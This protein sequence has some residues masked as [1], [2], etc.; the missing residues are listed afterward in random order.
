MKLWTLATLFTAVLAAPAPTPEEGDA[1]V[2]LTPDNFKDTISAGDDVWWIKFYSPYC[3]HCVAFAPTW[4]ELHKEFKDTAG[5]KFGNVNCATFGDLCGSEDV[6]AYPA[7]NL[8]KGGE[9]V[10]TKPAKGAKFF[11]GYIKEQMSKLTGEGEKKEEEKKGEDK[12]EKKE[13]KPTTVKGKFPQ[14]PTSSDQVNEE[15]PGVPKPPAASSTGINPEGAS[16]ELDHK[17]FIRRVTATRDS[18]FIQFYSPSSPYSRDIQPAWR[19]MA[20]NAKGKLDIGQVNC[21]VEKELCAEANADEMPTLK[22]FASSMSVKYT[23]LRGVGDLLQFLDRAVSARATKDITLADYKNLIKSA[24]DDEDDVTFVYLYDKATSSEDFQ[25]LEKLAVA[26]IGTVNIV[27]SSDPKLVKELEADQVPALFSVSADKVVPYLSQ[28]PNEIRDHGRLMKWAK[29]NRAPL[30]PQLTPSN[31]ADIFSSKL[32]VLAILDPRDEQ[33]TR[34][35]LKELRAS[36]RELQSVAAKE[37]QEEIA[38]LR[39]NKQLKIDEAKDKGDEKAE[40]E[41]NKIRIEPKERDQVGIAWIDGVFWERWVKSRY[42]SSEGYTSRIVINEESTG[43][44]WDRNWGNGIILPSRSQILETIAEIASAAPRVRA[45]TLRGPVESAVFGARNW[46]L[47]HQ[48]TSV[49]V[50]TV[51]A[52]LVWYRRK[53]LRAASGTSTGGILGKLD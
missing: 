51:A 13:E 11:Q 6:N 39:K 1:P 16:V 22:Y 19:Q 27:K 15:Y 41:A 5:L 12:E 25:A 46:V 26:T 21:D 50:F 45:K 42:G 37:Q 44:Y 47:E 29:D 23:G 2:D 24:S 32:V 38:Q 8:Y 53:H 4:A 17:E 20:R 36:A 52:G 40:G 30:V 35:A 43:R 34:T 18:W 9:K 31:S 10:D 28:S 3:P 48:A 14:Y 7:I 33:D 49:V